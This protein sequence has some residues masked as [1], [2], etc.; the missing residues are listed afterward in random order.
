MAQA[1]QWEQ[2]L[3]LSGLA[4]ATRFFETELRMREAEQLVKNSLA[5]F[6]QSTSEHEDLTQAVAAAKTKLVIL[7]Q[8]RRSAYVP[9]M[10]E[11]THSKACQR[12][13]DLT[14]CCAEAELSK[15][16]AEEE[17]RRT[18]AELQRIL[19]HNSKFLP[20]FVAKWEHEAQVLQ[21]ID[22]MTGLQSRIAELLT[23]TGGP[24]CGEPRSALLMS[25]RE[26]QERIFRSVTLPADCLA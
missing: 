8:S 3:T 25:G 21:Q 9:E 20:Y 12:L 6:Y 17:Y 14:D 15:D 10:P 18:L 5:K 24:G 26:A 11:D 4:K 7:F 16:A 23:H 2:E 1:E 22:T 19:S 13:K